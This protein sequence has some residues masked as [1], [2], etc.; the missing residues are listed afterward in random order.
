MQE[1]LQKMEWSEKL[2]QRL[3]KAGLTL[4]VSDYIFLSCGTALLALVFLHIAV[5][6]ALVV[7]IGVMIGAY[8]PQL[9]LMLAISHRQNILMEQLPDVFDFI[10]RSMQAGHAFNASLQMAAQ[11]APEPIASEFI[12]AF[13]QANLGMPIQK[14]LSD[15]ASRVDCADMRYFATAVMINK[16]VGGDL[17]GLLRGVSDL[18]RERLKLKLLIRAMTAEG[19]MSAWILGSLP[20][21][22]AAI[23]YLIN[24]QSIAPLWQQESGRKMVLYALGLM[25]AG[26][27]WMMQL[28]KVRA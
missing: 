21:I 8:L 4:T 20:L 16:D 26:I 10:A 15:L 27:I 12:L 7:F 18:I 2:D 9:F 3:L 14:A 25:F 11:E 19:R 28:S 1:W 22:V 17:A 13:N 5:D 23:L 24:A 6:S